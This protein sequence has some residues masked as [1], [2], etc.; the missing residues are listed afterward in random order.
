MKFSVIPTDKFKGEAKRLIRKFPSLKQELA[1][2][3]TVLET[4]ADTGTSLGNDTYSVR[5]AI[6][7]VRVKAKVVVPE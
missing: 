1:D 5:I 3:N 7:R 2:L 4:K 6:K